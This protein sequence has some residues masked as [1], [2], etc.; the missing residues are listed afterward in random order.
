MNN[1]VAMNG[2]VIREYSSI[3]TMQSTYGI[4]SSCTR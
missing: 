4:A 2:I 3:H 1:M